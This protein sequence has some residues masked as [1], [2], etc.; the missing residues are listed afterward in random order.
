[1]QAATVRVQ[2]GAQNHVAGK[3]RGRAEVFLLDVR[4]LRAV[5]S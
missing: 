1:M 5:T 3:Q 4:V 2:H